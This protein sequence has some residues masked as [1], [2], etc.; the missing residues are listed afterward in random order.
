[1]RGNNGGMVDAT[2]PSRGQGHRDYRAWGGTD[3]PARSASPYGAL[4]GR[5]RAAHHGLDP[6]PRDRAPDHRDGSD[7]AGEIIPLADAQAIIVDRQMITGAQMK[8][9]RALLGID[10]RELARL[11]GVSLPTIQRMEVSDGIVRAMVDSLEK[12]VNAIND[13]GVELI[14]EGA[15]SEGTGR[16]ARLLDRQPP[17][18]PSIEVEEILSASAGA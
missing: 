7:A 18:R 14:V 12:V 5:A 15:R 16:G 2:G 10:Q 17:R 11:S 13:A 9:A 8:A 1:M 3:S 6:G 4:P